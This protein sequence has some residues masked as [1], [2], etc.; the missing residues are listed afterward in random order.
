[1][2]DR[3]RNLQ[4]ACG[5]ILL[6]LVLVNL[7]LFLVLGV[8]GRKLR[9]AAIP[10][11]VPVV[12]FLVGVGLLVAAP[13]VKGA[14]Y[15]RVDAEGIHGDLGRVFAAYRTATLAAFALRE[16]AGLL[17]LVLAVITANPWWCWGLG[18]A[19]VVAMLFDWPKKEHL[20]L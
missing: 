11:A 13:A 14:V 6:G 12:L 10:G 8:L 15:K 16:A 18:G 9:P 5:A 20:G 3:I 2:L 4:I 17:G 1:M 7:A 19:A